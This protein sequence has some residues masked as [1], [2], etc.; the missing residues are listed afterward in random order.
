M[1]KITDGVCRL[2]SII[3]CILLR[4]ATSVSSR[5][6]DETQKKK[7]IEIERS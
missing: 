4:E 3:V 7:K 2:I 6:D 5:R 1:C